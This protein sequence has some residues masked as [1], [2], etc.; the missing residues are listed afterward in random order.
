MPLL[1]FHCRTKTFP[2]LGSTEDL[3]GWSSDFTVAGTANEFHTNFPPCISVIPFN[4]TFSIKITIFLQ[5]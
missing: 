5:K 1:I 4:I 2:G 3:T